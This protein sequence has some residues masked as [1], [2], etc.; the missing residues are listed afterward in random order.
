M[1]VI[2]QA[3]LLHEAESPFGSAFFS[4]S[5]GGLAEPSSSEAGG[6]LAEVAEQAMRWL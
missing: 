3:P 5:D 6:V 2:V 4:T 1:P